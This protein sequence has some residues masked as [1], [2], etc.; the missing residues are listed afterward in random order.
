MTW[1]FKGIES[2][3]IY[4]VLLEFFFTSPPEGLNH[5]AIKTLQFLHQQMCKII[6]KFKLHIGIM[7]QIIAGTYSMNITSTFAKKKKKIMTKLR[8]VALVTPIPDTWSTLNKLSEHTP[9]SL[10]ICTAKWSMSFIFLNGI[11][12]ILFIFFFTG[13]L[14]IVNLINISTVLLKVIHTLYL[15]IFLNPYGSVPTWHM[16]ICWLENSKRSITVWCLLTL[17]GL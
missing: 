6:N 15:F 7:N 10:V 1:Q 17:W 3:G 14:H 2:H 4:L 13:K 9:P 12:N 11:N 8:F 5:W 16:A